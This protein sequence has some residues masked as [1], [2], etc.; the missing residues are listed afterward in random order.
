M[1]RLLARLVLPL[2]VL[3]TVLSLGISPAHA[4]TRSGD[5]LSRINTLRASKGVQPLT[6]DPAL[7]AFA[8]RW[9]DH[10]ASVNLLSHNPAL[11]Q[12]PGSWTKAGENVGVGGDVDTLFQAFVNSP[13]HYENLID[14]AFNLVGIGTTVDAK[15]TIWTTHDFE[16]RSTATAH[17][18]TTTTAAVTAPRAAAAPQPAKPSAPATTPVT[19]PR[20]APT[21]RAPLARHSVLQPTSTAPTPRRT[22]AAATSSPQAA[23]PTTSA[24]TTPG[25][26]LLRIDTA[27]PTSAA[28]QL[29]TACTTACAEHAHHGVLHRVASVASRLI[30]TVLSLPSLL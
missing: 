23:V 11:A 21:Q 2:A 13:H 27:H 29:P 3:L 6:L 14:P 4:D 12:S 8:Q 24:P 30:S 5:W 7:S 26:V 18:T 15:G 20:P 9:A 25:P 19:R 28:P 17:P 10:M 16:A 1:P 22:A